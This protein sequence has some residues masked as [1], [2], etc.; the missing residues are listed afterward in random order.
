MSKEQIL[1]AFNGRWRIKV[2]SAI[3]NH[4]E[5][6]PITYDVLRRYCLDFFKTGILIGEGFSVA[7]DEQYGTIIC[8]HDS[9]L[10]TSDSGFS[11]WWDMYGKKID[12]GKCEKKWEKLSDA[13]KRACIAATPAYVASTPDIQYRRNPITYLNN[14]S[15][16]NQIIPRNNGTDSKLTIDQQ[17]ISKLADILTD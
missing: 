2:E 3:S 12:R 6:T 16:E 9:I 8:K 14:K 10:D 13:E 15:W 1:Q 7:E 5:Q 11:E 17:R 4:Q